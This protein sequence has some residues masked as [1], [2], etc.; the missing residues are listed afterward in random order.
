MRNICD[1]NAYSRSHKYECVFER[2]LTIR[3]TFSLSGISFS[4]YALYLAYRF[5]Y[6]MCVLFFCH[7]V[8]VAIRFAVFLLFV[9]LKMCGCSFSF[10]Q[11]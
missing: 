9:N 3:A 11:K 5:S 4:I 1:F 10:E 2:E 7:S 8:F 6:S